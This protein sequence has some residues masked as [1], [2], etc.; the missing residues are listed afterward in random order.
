[1]KTKCPRT[2]TGKHIFH[3]VGLILPKTPYSIKDVTVKK[4]IA[5]GIIDN[6]KE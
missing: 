3:E 4:C 2:T 1:M 6:S 5:C